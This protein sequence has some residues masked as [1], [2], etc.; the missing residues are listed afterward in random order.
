MKHLKTFDI[1]NESNDDFNSFV[2]GDIVRLIWNKEEHIARIVNK[3]S[4]NS[5]IVNIQRNNHFLPKGVL[6]NG[7]DI[8][9]LV[10]GNSEPA[11]GDSWT[12]FKMGKV[13]ND[14]AINNYGSGGNDSVTNIDTAGGLGVAGP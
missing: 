10:T 14:M 8:I 5:Y 2:N 11:E 7:D 13:S 9:E 1:Y 6:V 4:N 12:K 3:K